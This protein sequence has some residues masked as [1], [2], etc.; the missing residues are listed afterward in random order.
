MTGI[1]FRL[2]V[3]FTLAV[4]IFSCSQK[5]DDTGIFDPQNPDFFADTISFVT[6]QDTMSIPKDR[7]SDGFLYIGRDIP[8]PGDT[9]AWAEPLIKLTLPSV[10]GLDSAY[11]EY[12]LYEYPDSLNISQYFD[13]K[14]VEVLKITGGWTAEG[15]AYPLSGLTAVD[16]VLIVPDSS[17]TK[18]VLRFELKKNMISE[19]SETDTTGI[20]GFYLRGI[21]NISPVIKFYSA[22]FTYVSQRPAVTAYYTFTDSLIATDGGDS[23]LFVTNKSPVSEDITLAYK[24]PSCIDPALNRIKLGGISGESYICRIPLDSIP[25]GAVILTGRISLT[26]INENDP[27]YGGIENQVSTNREICVYLMT[28]SLWYDDPAVLNY[29]TLNVSTYKINLGGPANYLLMDAPVQKWVSD[30]DSNYGFMIKSKNWGS[31]FGFSVFEKPSFNISYII[32]GNDR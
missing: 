9:A 20:A 19:W 6:N 32:T 16:T 29:D 17:G 25:A 21:D 13:G 22:G 23:T 2:T 7:I 8:A 15:V 24:A 5:Y 26:A 1:K 30:P 27:V 28:D 11:V 14:S 12:K 10:Y 31:P 4:M 3:F 18:F